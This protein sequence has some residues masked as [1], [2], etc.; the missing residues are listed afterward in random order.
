MT[1]RDAG[2]AVTVESL[3]VELSRA[4]VLV[5]AF[6][7]RFDSVFERAT[8]VLPPLS[9]PLA[10][11]PETLAPLLR[12]EGELGALPRLL[13]EVG[14]LD[15]AVDLRVRRAKDRSD[16]LVA[17]GDAAARQSTELATAAVSLDALS[18]NLKLAALNASV[19]TV[20][21]GAT[22]RGPLSAI[23]GELIRLSETNLVCVDELRRLSSAVDEA[24]AEAQRLS[25]AIVGE[26]SG[27]RLPDA[28]RGLERAAGWIGE[29]GNRCRG[30]AEEA[31]GHIGGLMVL[32]QRQDI[33]RQGLEH[34]LEVQQELWHALRRAQ[35]HED[36]DSLRF[37]AC[38]AP[39]CSRL[40]AALR[41]DVAEF[42][43]ASAASL[44]AIHALG[45]ALGDLSSGQTPESDLQA[46]ITEVDA[47][48]DDA[49][50]GSERQLAVA[51]EQVEALARARSISDA[52]A[53]G[54]R[55][56]D[57]Q[58]TALRAI[59]ALI[60]LE[61]ARDPGLSQALPVVQQILDSQGA[62][63]EAT[64]AGSPIERAVRA[65][66]RAVQQAN[67][68]TRAARSEQALELEDLAGRFTRCKPQLAQLAAVFTETLGGAN[69][70]GTHLDEQAKSL[71]AHVQ[72]LRDEVAELATLDSIYE[73]L[74]AWAE[75]R[76][77]A[78]D[79]AEAQGF[80]GKERLDGLLDRF[81][82]LS[83]R[84][85][86]DQT[87]QLDGDDGGTLTLF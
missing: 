36:L 1:K 25:D 10:E 22:V 77:P 51:V 19:A 47:A 2:G 39:A 35:E 31:G 76:I 6:R 54:L 29:T 46:A 18:S 15:G 26:A 82:V 69:R 64:R 17:L 66:T 57:D 53:S 9:S 68:T 30:H 13:T 48:L 65:I 62:F 11:I 21:H 79:D 59:S 40:N 44:G 33:Q 16:A 52:F 87:E 81:H 49:L 43:D 86:T 14:Q 60:R 4:S 12:E 56:L 23:T 58:R 83:Y 37:V 70:V 61:V 85:A 45:S 32:A 8:E 80:A 73:Q 3:G 74:E 20:R 71:D 7:Q 38:A 84:N 75:E 55:E 72:R 42:I 63:S 28:V 41:D 24:V 78:G 34:L 27:D 67:K 5:D 50:A